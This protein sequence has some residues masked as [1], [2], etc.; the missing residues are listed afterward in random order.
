MSSGGSTT[1]ANTGTS[2]STSEITRALTTARRK[3]NAMQWRI[4]LPA[5]SVGVVLFGFAMYWVK[6]SWTVRSASFMFVRD[7]VRSLGLLSFLCACLPSDK[8][9]PK[10]G[11]VFIFIIGARCLY[12]HIKTMIEYG[13]QVMEHRDSGTPCVI[14]KAETDCALG[15]FT[16]WGVSLMFIVLHAWQLPY[17]TI[18]LRLPPR[19][20]AARMWV[21]LAWLH[22][23]KAATDFFVLLP[24]MVIKGYITGRF[25]SAA[26]VFTLLHGM[27]G[28]FGGFL[29]RWPKFRQRVH[30]FLL[31]QSG[32]LTAASGIAAFLG[33]KTA[34]MVMELA[35]S[36]CKYVS[37]D[38]LKKEDMRRSTPDASLGVYATEC[39]LQDVD[40]FMSHS[41]HDPPDEKWEA[42]QT[43]R[44]RFKAQHHREPRVW[45]DKYCIDQNNIEASLVCLAVFLAGCH[46]L[47]IIAGPTYL[48]RLWCVEEVFVFLQMGRA[49]ESIELFPLCSDLQSM[50][51]NFD[52]QAATCFLRE[53]NEK[54]LASIEAGCD[55]FEAFNAEVQRALLHALKCTSS[56]TSLRV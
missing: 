29:L 48:S 37:M 41:W 35:Q 56:T 8:W 51:A 45:I 40:A 34:K 52:V 13:E 54:L 25:S 26:F 18:S 28:T 47:L 32:N 33:N 15:A 11:S 1:V 30:F 3:F 24:A 21:A 9:A 14:E 2:Q 6:T 55:G 23:T 44:R 53:D 36:N 12:F 20:T 19:A 7:V 42:I 39:C 22:L 49:P 50:I 27:Y 10:V 4:R 16:I 38:K 43:W 46:T 5:L 17:L 31:A